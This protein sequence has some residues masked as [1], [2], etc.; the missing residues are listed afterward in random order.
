MGLDLADSDII[1]VGVGVPAP[2]TEEGIVFGSA[3]LCPLFL[4]LRI[5]DVFILK[6]IL[7]KYCALARFSG[8]RDMSI[9][10]TNGHVTKKMMLFS[11][12]LIAGNLLQQTYNIADT[13]IV[14]RGR[15]FKSDFQLV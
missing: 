15:R 10:L 8:N 4:L 9:D 6:F 5:P 13:V 1:G 2:V 3:N 11:L 7:I 14:G 12:P